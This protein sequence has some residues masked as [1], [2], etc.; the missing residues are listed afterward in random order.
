MR[1]VCD[2]MLGRLAKYLRILGFDAAYARNEALL[3][4]YR[5][6]ASDRVFLTRRLGETRFAR[7]VRVRS[8]T[9]R[10]QLEEIR[11]LIRPFIR[12]ENV[13]NRCIE[14]NTELAEV[15]KEEIESLVPEFVYHNY[16][17]FRR[18]PAC[19]RVY[20]EGSHT[21]GMNELLEEMLA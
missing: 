1:F 7:T 13:F 21:K 11:G 12:L 20:W 17:R 8:D 5:R 6:E 9:V 4:R 15:D 2:V 14:C 3:D 10:K 16:A 18:C 19:G